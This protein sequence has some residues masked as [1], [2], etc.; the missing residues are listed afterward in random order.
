MEGKSG[1]SRSHPIEQETQ[2]ALQ[3][4]VESPFYATEYKDYWTRLHATSPQSTMLT[5]NEA[6]GN[7]HNNMEKSPSNSR[8]QANEPGEDNARPALHLTPMCL[9]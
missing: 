1:N 5:C 8:T 7:P 4:L 9:P 2:L 3:W 6:G